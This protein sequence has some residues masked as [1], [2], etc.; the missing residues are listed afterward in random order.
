MGGQVKPVVARQTP[1]LTEWPRDQVRA[2]ALALDIAVVSG[3]ALI[4]GSIRLGTPS[5][6]VDESFT[7]GAVRETFLN[8]I[9]QYHWFYYSVVTAWT[10]LA[11]TSEWALRAP[12]VFA[13]MLACGLL[14]PL[15]RML[16]DR[17]VALASGLFLATS[18]FLVKWSQQARGYTLVLAVSILA[19]LLLLRALERGS[20]SAWLLYGVAF[21]LVFA[22]HP[23]SAFVLVPAHIVLVG[24]RRQK[25]L[26]H[27]LLAACAIVALGVPWAFA[28]V[29]Q[30]PPQ[31]WL[32]RP[33]PGVAVDTLLDISGAAGLG[34]LVA[35]IG[36]VV[37]RRAGRSDLALWLGV[38]ATA[39]FVLALAVSFVTPIYLDRYL[40]TAAPAFAMLAGVAVL[41]VGRRAGV[42]LGAAAAVATTIGLVLW[43][44]EGDGGNWRGEDWRGAV[45]T[46]LERRSESDA[47][48]VVPWWSS[49]AAR[50]YGAYPTGISSDDSLWVLVW[51]EDGHELPQSQRRALGFGDHQLVERL[52]FGERVSAQ[53]WRRAP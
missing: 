38:W 29:K 39:P 35:A 4:L 53:L 33:S 5:L 12:S 27:G 47:V 25:L 31:D 14:V 51:S 1:W 49:P 21:S 23:V 37:L 50:Y 10:T 9:D 48:M 2:G 36:L 18:P 34:L 43:Y 28:R 7:A 26:P 19:T 20:R 6:W 46:V 8:P 41:G 17:W 42:P 3:V 16:F 40:I 22:M 30:T 13:S 52:Q 45:R 32:D 44:T 15:V 24:Q 11:G